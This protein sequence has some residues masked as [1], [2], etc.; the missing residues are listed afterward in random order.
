MLK[1]V[2]WIMARNTLKNLESSIDWKI[3]KPLFLLGSVAPDINIAFP[4]HTID[5]TRERFLNRIVKVETTKSYLVKSF[6]MGVVNHYICDY[7]CYAHNL[8]RIDP[9]HA[10]YERFMKSHL[11]KHTDTISKVSDDIRYQFDEIGKHVIEELYD[12]E[13]TRDNDIFSKFRMTPINKNVSSLIS[14]V[15]VNSRDHA[16]FIMNIICKVH[17]KYLEDIDALIKD[18][19]FVQLDRILL[20][21]NYANEVSHRVTKLLATIQDQMDT[22]AMQDEFR[23][24]ICQD[25][26]FELGADKYFIQ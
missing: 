3:N 8:G 19:W 21:I 24:F 18:K 12:F 13:D 9:A 14:T 1:W 15:Q 4:V 20:D 16:E 11:K 5:K 17:N 25:S 6:Y 26:V 23:K 2:H 10:I 7:F 22:S